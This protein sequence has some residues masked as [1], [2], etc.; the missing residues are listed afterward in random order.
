M[1]DRVRSPEIAGVDLDGPATRGL[2]GEVVPGLLMGEAAA[3]EYRRIA[4]DVLRPRRNHALDRADHV[5]R[6]AEPEI[7]EVG[8]TERDGIVRMRAQDR[9]PRGDGAIEIAIGP[10]SQRSDMVALALRRVDGERLRR[11]RFL[12]RDWDDRLLEGEHR[13]IALHAMR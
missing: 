1:G 2:G 5:L 10:G 13:E 3:G 8:E 7:D 12:E 6:A 4:R 11:A 9:L